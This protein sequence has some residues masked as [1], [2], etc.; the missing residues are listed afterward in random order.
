[1]RYI[2]HNSP[3]DCSDN[4]TSDRFRNEDDITEGTKLSFSI[5]QHQCKIEDGM[6]GINALILSIL[7]KT[8]EKFWEKIP[9]AFSLLQ[10]ESVIRSN[11]SSSFLRFQFR[12]K[13]GLEKLFLKFVKG[14]SS[15][16]PGKS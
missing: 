9:A 15:A 14:A 13:G 11:L 3:P 8:P 12:I 2:Y 6:F 16:K 5:V 1:M 7:G 4:V 10:L